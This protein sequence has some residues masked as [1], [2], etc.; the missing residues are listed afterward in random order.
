ME[1]N[2]YKYSCIKCNYFSNRLSNYNKHLS[3]EYTTPFIQEGY[4]MIY[5]QYTLR[6]SKRQRV[7]DIL[8]ESDIGS[9]IYYPVPLHL[10][11]CFADLGYT[12]GD[13]PEAEKAAQ[14]VFSIPIYPELSQEE[15]AYVVDVLNSIA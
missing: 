8:K 7:L 1:K 13:M 6:S 9:V 3:S 12:E 4:S 14:E 2:K 10:Q 11:A 5:N 15:Q